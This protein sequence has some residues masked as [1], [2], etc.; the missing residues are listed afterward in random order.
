MK[1]L[2]VFVGKIREELAPVSAKRCRKLSLLSY[3][4]C[5]QLQMTV[6]VF[7]L[8]KP[9]FY[10]V[11][12]FFFPFLLLVT[13]CQSISSPPSSSFVSNLPRMIRSSHQRDYDNTSFGGDEKVS[14]A[15]AFN[16]M[17]F[18]SSALGKSM[19]INSA[20]SKIPQHRNLFWNMMKFIYVF[21]WPPMKAF[22]CS[23]PLVLAMDHHHPQNNGKH[24]HSPVS[25][26]SY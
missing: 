2:F 15:L 4:E 8:M 24:Q 16:Q 13:A 14:A 3:P 9:N 7:L 11:F 21:R 17:F 23:I 5:G 26:C 6:F 18:S 12:F 25:L 1:G 10:A 19:Y 22:L 20:F